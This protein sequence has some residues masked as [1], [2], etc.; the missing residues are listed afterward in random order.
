MAESEYII[1]VNQARIAEIYD[2]SIPAVAKW[3]IEPI[4][5][6]K[7]W[8][9][10][11]VDVVRIKENMW[12]EQQDSHVALLRAAKIRIANSAATKS[13]IEI[14]VLMNK[15]ISL[16]HAMILWNEMAGMLKSQLY[17]LTVV[18]PELLVSIAD[19]LKIR[20]IL[21]AAVDD[22]LD[23][24]Q[25]FDENEHI[26]G[27][28]IVSDSDKER[29]AENNQAGLGRDPSADLPKK[30]KKKSTKKI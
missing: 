21:E 10:N 8:K 17:Q 27:L 12:K 20:K 30:R 24:I 9:Y 18:L 28:N 29:S 2:V 4:N 14:E 3:D 6:T 15:W 26:E 11:L 25:G 7:P 16:E 13:E 5:S 23:Y 1:E 22:L 19:K